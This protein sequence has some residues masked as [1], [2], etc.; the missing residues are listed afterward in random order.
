MHPPPLPP[1]GDDARAAEI[2]EMPRN[3]WLTDPKDLHK[4]ADAN[5]LVGDEIEETKARAIGQG[6]KEKIE[7]ERFFPVGHTGYYIWL[8]RYEQGGVS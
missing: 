5:F 7:R 2:R 1:G 4:I 8:D 3:F 6:A